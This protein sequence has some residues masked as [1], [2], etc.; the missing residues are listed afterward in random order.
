MEVDKVKFK[1]KSAALD[2][3]GLRAQD[4]TFSSRDHLLL[5][6]HHLRILC[7][8]PAI[9]QPTPIFPGLGHHLAQAPA[10]PA[11]IQDQT[12]PK[13]AFDID[14]LLSRLD[15]PAPRVIVEETWMADASC[16]P[17]LLLW[18]HVLLSSVA[19]PTCSLPRLCSAPAALWTTQ[20]RV[21]MSV[22]PVQPQR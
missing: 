9:M 5:V 17:W 14:S 3:R 21:Q 10:L 22:P 12:T 2:I 16:S 4:P 6:L 8:L 15:R 20:W 19:L 11:A 13:K 1:I 7:L 18:G